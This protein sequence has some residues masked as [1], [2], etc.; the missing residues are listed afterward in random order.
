MSEIK[1]LRVLIPHW[2]EHNE[3]HAAEFIRWASHA[4][5]AAV[6]LR[7]HMDHF[8]SARDDELRPPR[9]DQTA[10][11]SLLCRPPP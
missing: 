9:G 10:G 5:E 6:D 11:D 3:G 7:I 2:I 8:H 1:K 4:G